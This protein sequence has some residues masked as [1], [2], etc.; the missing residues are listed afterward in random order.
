LSF[1]A[2]IT[3][4]R[5]SRLGEGHLGHIAASLEK[6]F[7]AI[8]AA[9]HKEAKAHS[10]WY[11]GDPILRLVTNLSDGA[12]QMAVA[13]LPKEWLSAA[14]LPKP[15][16]EYLE[17]LLKPSADQVPDAAREADLKKRFNEAITSIKS[18][19]ELPV[20]LGEPAEDAYARASLLMLRQ[21][22]MLIA[23]W[24]GKDDGH[25]GGASEVVKQ[26]FAWSI[27]VVWISSVDK[28]EPVLITQMTN[29]TEPKCD[30]CAGPIE[31][32][33]QK[34]LGT[35]DDPREAR[36]LRRG[37]TLSHTPD[38]RLAAFLN[39]SPR[40]LCIWFAYKWL[41]QM[42][43]V[44]TWRPWVSL[45]D[46]TAV[47]KDWDSFLQ[48]MPPESD[49]RDRFER[50]LLP[51]FTA[52]D[53][54]ASWYAHAY[55]SAYVLAYIFAVAA[56]GL[57]LLGFVIH[58][59]CSPRN[60]APLGAEWDSQFVPYPEYEPPK[61]REFRRTIFWRHPQ[62][63]PPTAQDLLFF[64]AILVL[65]EIGL[66]GGTILMVWY[67]SSRKWHDRWLDYRALAETLRHLRILG[68]LGH[69]EPVRLAEASARPGAGWLVWYLRATMRELGPPVGLLD[70]S[71]QHHVLEA[72]EVSEIEGQIEYHEYNEIVLEHLHHRL[73]TAG[74]FCFFLTIA[75][76]VIF[77]VL[78]GVDAQMQP[79]P[80]W[81]KNA[82]S[83][84]NMDDTRGPTFI[85]EACAPWIG[86]FASLL[87]AL[88]AAVS[89]IRFTGD[90]DGFAERSAETSEGLKALRESFQNARTRLSFD[91]T[92]AVLFETARL[93]GNDLLGWRALYGRKALTLPA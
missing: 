51:R 39:D 17:E 81:L 87:P 11:S 56:V 33:I 62:C 41:T 38:D 42:F 88:G 91:T 23:V 83:A 52:A 50:I 78:I 7:S 27:P 57:A 46:E 54:L 89:G 31:D 85:L 32:A 67:G 64:K 66:I 53:A 72:I 75:M 82:M 77:V 59:E 58:P 29:V 2:A 34:I 84:L 79:D 35:I 18:I 6:V 20:E 1:A 14:I 36:I 12:D 40:K 19:A 30:A 21:A 8:D 4:H 25:I 13:A 93:M 74:N 90:F 5:L 92:A 15:R 26:A 3:G 43:R 55:R 48:A 63:P 68:P 60:D 80:V 61:A 44:W 28:H 37:G 24:D 76:L 45:N 65:F 73:H 86:F 22:D 71:Y 69:Y 9:C 49:L 16:A 10:E 47:R 70:S